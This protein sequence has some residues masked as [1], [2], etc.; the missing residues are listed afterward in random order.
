MQGGGR[1][2]WRAGPA[3]RGHECQ[4][5]PVSLV[6]PELQ[7]LV[8]ETRCQPPARCLVAAHPHSPLPPLL[9]HLG[10]RDQAQLSDRLKFP[11]TLGLPP[12]SA[13]TP[14]TQILGED[15]HGYLC[16]G[17]RD[18]VRWP[19]L[20]TGRRKKK[21]SGFYHLVPAHVPSPSPYTPL[22]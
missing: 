9:L 14:G 21:K 3:Q 6:A 8:R 1:L 12:S 22:P 15:M 18:S 11:G 19:G 5:A 16:Q 20:Q 13:P 17:P 7:G 10:H 4:S 2:S